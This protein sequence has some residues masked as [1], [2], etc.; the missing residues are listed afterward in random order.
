[1]IQTILGAILYSTPLVL[2]FNFKDKLKGLLYVSSLMIGLHL[3]VAI[4]TQLFH[5]FSYGVVVAI[6]SIVAVVCLAIFAHKEKFFEKFK[7][8]WL[9]VLIFIV[10]ALELSSVHYFYKGIVSDV[11]GLNAVSRDF[12]PYPHYSDEWAGVSLA[13]WTIREGSLPLENSLWKDQTFANGLVVFYS[14]ISEFFLLLN[15]AP[16]FGWSIFAIVNGLMI[17]FLIY[18]LLRTNGI[19]QFSSAMAA[20]SLP[21]IVNGV[22]VSGIWFLTPHIFALS[23]FLLSL[24]SLSKKEFKIGLLQSL[25][26]LALYP[27]LMVFV[28]PAF[29]AYIFQNKVSKKYIFTLLIPAIMVSTFVFLTIGFSN[30]FLQIRYWLTRPNLDGGIISLPI[31][32]VI[33]ILILPFVAVGIAELI[34]RKSYMI[35]G[36]VLVGLAFWALYSF[37]DGIIIIDQSR[38]VSVAAILLM[39]PAGFGFEKLLIKGKKFSLILKASFLII[40]VSTTFFYPV[41]NAWS[42]FYLSVER[43]GVMQKYQSSAPITRYL[44]SDDLKLFSGISEKVFIAPSWKGLVIAAATHNYPLDSKSSTITNKFVP[45]SHFINAPCLEKQGI[46]EHFGLEYAYSSKF[47]CPGF[48][49]IGQS[50]ENLYLYRFQNE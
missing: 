2:V 19:G 23:I 47:E 43:D 6:H 20:L 22:N 40:F 29:L 5:V 17:A 16:L 7:F 44:H 34:K 15:I 18:L 26:C 46:S 36:P 37:F 24:V 41:S 9:V 3:A 1:M 28:V 27:P 12:Y 25:V 13:D 8:D 39:I 11:G 4:L 21:L 48:V 32:V 38:A 49:E 50:V 30:T 33:P 14:L 45:Y 35:L 10:V 42:R 31:W